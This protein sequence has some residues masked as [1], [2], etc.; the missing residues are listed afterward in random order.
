MQP[1]EEPWEKHKMSER[2]TEIL[3]KLEE[4]MSA[5]R[6]E[7][8][9]LGEIQ[10][11]LDRRKLSEIELE[12]SKSS[13]TV[14]AC[15]DSRLNENVSQSIFLVFQANN[16]PESLVGIF[17]NGEIKQLK[18]GRVTQGLLSKAGFGEF[19]GVIANF[20]GLA[21]PELARSGD[22]IQIAHAHCEVHQLE[23]HKKQ[24]LEWLSWRG[25]ELSKLGVSEGDFKSMPTPHEHIEGEVKKLVGA[26]PNRRVIG[27]SV[28]FES[29]VA[30]VVASH[31]AKMPAEIEIPDQKLQG[32]LLK[33]QAPI[34]II[35]GK[36]EI[37]LQKAAG[38]K[39]GEYFAV[40]DDGSADSKIS[41][42]YAV[43]Q[44]NKKNNIEEIVFVAGTESEARALRNKWRENPLLRDLEKG[45]VEFTTRAV[46][47]T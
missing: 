43:S 26:N 45:G 1:L 11:N 40:T 41:L 8:W 22:V 33:A 32:E 46:S 12:E 21:N 2:F 14:F 23:E 6:A 13:I 18:E 29:G 25:Y 3:G 39:P 47:E 15:S 28:D 42:I 44:L 4:E 19:R 27:V 10:K 31:K 24:I 9:L 17:S 7:D 35:I 5:L 37:D 30:K 36:E 34:G 38:A 20:G 16:E